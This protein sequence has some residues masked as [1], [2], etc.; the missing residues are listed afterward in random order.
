MISQFVAL[1]SMSP[2]ELAQ[3]GAALAKGAAFDAVYGLWRRR[4]SEGWTRSRVAANIAADEGWLSKQFVGPRNWT[5]E[6]FGTL[7]VGLNGEI[8]IIVRAVEDQVTRTNYD[9]YAE[10]LEPLPPPARPAL[11][12][13]QKKAAIG[14]SLPDPAMS[15]FLEAIVSKKEAAPVPVIG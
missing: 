8:E 6:S 2:K 15:S 11:V 4:S 10:Y 5:M 12:P 3:Y 7:V 9:A 14:A 13:P 1:E